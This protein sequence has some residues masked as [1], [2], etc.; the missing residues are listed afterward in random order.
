MGS[1]VDVQEL[2]V[3]PPY[4]PGLARPGLLDAEMPSHTGTH[5]DLILKGIHISILITEKEKNGKR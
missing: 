1:V 5:L 4:C 2:L 3:V